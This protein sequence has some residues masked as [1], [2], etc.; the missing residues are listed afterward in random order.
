MTIEFSPVSEQKQGKPVKQ[1]DAPVGDDRP[2]QERDMAF[3]TENKASYVFERRR[4]MVGVPI[5]YKEKGCKEAQP[6]ERALPGTL[7]EE[8]THRYQ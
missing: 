5:S 1:V 3:P 2:G 8:I 4:T 7:C 6:R